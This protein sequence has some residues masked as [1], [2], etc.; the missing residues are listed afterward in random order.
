MPDLSIQYGGRNYKI[1]APDQATAESLIQDITQVTP[2]ATETPPSIEDQGILSSFATGAKEG[3]TGLG[4]LYDLAKGLTT[5]EGRAAA[6]QTLS[7]IPAEDYLKGAVREGLGTA[8]GAAALA[9]PVVGP[10]VAPFAYS[11]AR[12]AGDV[13]LSALG[14]Q[15]EKTPEQ[16]AQQLARETGGAYTGEILTR[17]LGKLATTAGRGLSKA[18]QGLGIVTGS[19]EALRQA[20]TQ[21]IAQYMTPEGVARIEEAQLT[22]KLQSAL[23]L[24]KTAAEIS[25]TPTGAAYEV[26]MGK[27]P[28]AGDVL[29]EAL[30]QRE[31]AAAKALKK[32]GTPS[33]ATTLGEALKGEL[34]AIEDRKQRMLGAYES[35][36]DFPEQPST[37]PLVRGE[38]I[39]AAT[40]D[41]F[42]EADDAVSQ[43]WNKV[44]TSTTVKIEP[45][46][47]SVTRFYDKLHKITKQGISANTKDLVNTVKS[48]AEIKTPRLSLGTYQALRRR[49]GEEWK[50]AFNA[51]KATE[52]R[53]LTDMRTQLDNLFTTAVETQGAGKPE[54]LTILRDAIAGTRQIN[55]KFNRGIVGRLLKKTNEGYSVPASNILKKIDETPEN[56]RE[57]MTK[58]GRD[59]DIAT[60]VRDAYIG[61]LASAKDPTAYLI[62]NEDKFKAIFADDF[63]NLVQYAQLKNTPDEL[64]GYSKLLSQSIPTKLLNNTEDLDKF[65]KRFGSDEFMMDN[66]RGKFIEKL[67]TK[68]ETTYADIFEK[69]KPFAERIFT[70]SQLKQFPKIFADIESRR[71]VGD[72]A[73]KASR[74]QSITAAGGTIL[75]RLM[76]SRG[77]VNSMKKGTLLGVGGSAA[78]GD[79]LTGLINLTAGLSLEKLGIRREAQLNQIVTEMLKDPSLLKF[80]TATPT[81]ANYTRLAAELGRRGYLASEEETIKE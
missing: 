33:D 27:E 48:Y 47:K 42:T 59:S 26:A 38:S 61:K 75:S 54:A 34:A 12:T 3:I 60:E 23:G 69:Q 55:E 36:L 50:I 57:I 21:E 5:S 32:L 39:R 6:Y 11:T 72:L 77:I 16:V 31:A 4:S 64:E 25:Q 62:K 63:D 51:G 67:E 76:N 65:V 49:L 18:K 44:P 53:V 22:N 2:V 68:R 10:A 29:T 45:G 40:L 52:A 43:L 56:V 9:I 19:P 37:T 28:G 78:S 81:K 7:E 70:E 35:G 58:F 79:L 1:S 74:G 80:A 13:I 8:G 66:L 14:L 30:L 17:G 73:A 20:A 41:K 15:K 24:P 71:S 46:L